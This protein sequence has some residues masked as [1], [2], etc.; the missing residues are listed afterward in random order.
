VMYNRPHFKPPIS[1]I[2][3]GKILEITLQYFL[4]RYFFMEGKLYQ[5]DLVLGS[6][7]QSAIII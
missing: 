2:R 1:G 4:T 3:P 6:G 5:L 7:I